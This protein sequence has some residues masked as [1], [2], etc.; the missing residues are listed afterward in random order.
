MRASTPKSPM[1]EWP[2]S[3]CSDARLVLAA[4]RD[5]SAFDSLYDRYLDAVLRFCFYRLGDWELAEDATSDIFLRVLANLAQ[6]QPAGHDA[7]FRCWLFTIARNV[8]ADSHRDRCRH[9]VDPLETAMN[10]RDS[11]PTPEEAVISVDDHQYIRA[12]MAQL[13]PEQR[14]LL[15]LRLAGLKNAEIARILGRSH[16]AVRKEQSRIVQSLR[17]LVGKQAELGVLHA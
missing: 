17:V 2:P 13:K 12:L 14:E 3:A 11:T 1:D 4:Q 15:E 16:D 5:P 9:P 6:Y 8:I 7:G 10:M